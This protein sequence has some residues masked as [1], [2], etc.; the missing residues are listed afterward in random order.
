VTG[1]YVYRGALLHEIY[2]WYVYG[3]YCS[4][5]IWAVNPADTSAAVQLVDT[6]HNIASFG[7]L[8]NG[9][10]IVLTFSNAIYRL[11]CA[12]TPDSDGDGQGNACDLDD[13]NDGFSDLVEASA[14]TN[15]LVRCGTNANPADINNDTVFDI[16]DIGAVAASFGLSVPPA[17]ERYNI[18]PDPPD[19]VVDITD[20]AAVG[21]RFGQ[22]CA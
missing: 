2:G 16:T 14:G 17:S 3:D 21:A 15:P 18:A 11:T 4:G 5:K 1:G 9:E 6:L 13:D 12:A 20:I 19:G 8:P 10:L 7:E 22:S